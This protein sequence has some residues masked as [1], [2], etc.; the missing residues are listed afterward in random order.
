M[1]KPNLVYTDKFVD[2]LDVFLWHIQKDFD[3]FF[4]SFGQSS[5]INF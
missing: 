2:V 1:F 4:S 3:S 5:L